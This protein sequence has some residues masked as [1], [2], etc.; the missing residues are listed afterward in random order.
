M[1]MGSACAQTLWF[2]AWVNAGCDWG[3]VT[4]SEVRS[5]TDEQNT[6]MKKSWLTESQIADLYKSEDIAKK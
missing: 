4:V 2:N 3:K 6:N 5:E 1:Q